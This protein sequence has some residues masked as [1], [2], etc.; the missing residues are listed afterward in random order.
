MPLVKI[1]GVVYFSPAFDH[2]LFLGFSDTSVE[3][4]DV[5]YVMC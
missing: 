3:Q 1:S 4:V 5:N 2:V